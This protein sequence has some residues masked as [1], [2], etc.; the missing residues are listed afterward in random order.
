MKNT[1]LLFAIFC[2]TMLFAQKNEISGKVLTL[3]K[4]PIESATVYLSAQKDSTLLDYTITDVLGNF[5]I[6]IK[7]ANEPSF[8]TVS[9]LGYEDYSTKIEDLK[10]IL[11]LGVITMQP[12]SD[13]MDELVIVTDAAPIRVKKDTLE[14]NAA[15]FKVRPD[16]TVKELL[17]Q[18]PGVEIDEA[19]K[20]KVN[21]KEVNNVLVN[22]KP[23]FGADGKVAIEN[24]PKDIINKVQIT[25]TKTKEEKIT[26]AKAT[27]NAK[28]INLTIDEDKNKGLFGRFIAGYGTDDRYES[29]LLFNYFKN[30]FK[31]SFLGSSNNINSQGFSTNEIMDNM[32]GGRNTYSSWSSDGSFSVN[33]LN[34]GGQKGISQTDMIGVN[35]SDNWGKKNKVS[36]NYLFNEVENNNKNKTRT[37]NLLPEN[38]FVTE[39]SSELKSKA[40]NHSFNYDIEMEIDSLTTLTIVPN[41]KRGISTTHTNS[42]SQTKN[43]FG[44]DLNKSNNNDIL[45]LDTYSFDN[46]ILL[47]RRFKKKGRSVSFGLENK[48]SQNKTNQ[49]KNSAAYFFQSTAADDIRNQQ[50]Q[51]TRHSDEYTVNAIYREPINKSQS[52][53]FKYDTTWQNDYQGKGTFDF[54]TANNSFTNYN[55]LLSYANCLKG[56]ITK[57]SVGYQIN[58]EKLWLSLTVGTGFNNYNVTSFYNNNHYV[59][60]RL[61]I[62]P[63]IDA[64][65]SVELGKSK[66]IYTNYSYNE[67]SPFLNQLLEYEDLSNPL[68]K[69]KGNKDLKTSKEHNVYLSFNNYDWQSRSGYYF[70]GGGTY[71]SRNIDNT[72]AYDENFVAT[73]TYINVYNTYHYWSGFNYNKSYKLSDKNKL[74]LSAG[75]NFSGD[76]NKGVLNNVAYTANSKSY[77]PKVNVTLDIDKKLTI[78]PNYA[79]SVSKTNYEN[80]TVNQSNYFTHKAGLMVTSY[81][82]KN[83]VFGSD[84][85]YEYNSNLSSNFRKDFLLWNASLGYNFYNERFLAKVKIYDILNQNQSVRRSV[86][87]TSISDTQNTIL[88]QYI[89]F[90][91]TYKLEKFAGK[92]KGNNIVIMD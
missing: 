67:R 56:T 45:N 81:M 7:K 82:P 58:T 74:S 66:R 26:G 90:S 38:R 71:S 72:V 42:A 43:E 8:L 63:E 68:F 30:D 3:E 89:M 51:A 78:Q 37:E 57:P 34:F 47:A 15:S 73:S 88:K 33:G 69:S 50:I 59:N 35:Y 76:L 4:V 16:A 65:A 2:S 49:L 92:K 39:S 75:F 91:L 9:Y 11:N 83:V 10:Q 5:K 87:P 27:G 70:Y 17:E 61:D 41:F 12:T 19:G 62:L 53:T 55:N 40:T 85:V 60:K 21:G 29:S 1:L 22:G 31:I 28:T 24:L 48:N 84:I 32:S 25:D 44:E 13:V 23:F 52:L 46:E 18:L 80:F 64:N 6:P 77:G 54:N 20:I 14:F 86:S 36:M 79:Y